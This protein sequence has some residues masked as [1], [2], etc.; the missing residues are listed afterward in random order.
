MIPSILVIM[1]AVVRS[2]ALADFLEILS[3]DRAS[4]GD[5]LGALRRAVW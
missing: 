4:W 1:Y 2:K 5:R 3:D